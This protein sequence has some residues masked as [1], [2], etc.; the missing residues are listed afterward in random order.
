MA[1][2][3]F[4]YQGDRLHYIRKLYSNSNTKQTEVIWR[5]GLKHCGL[6]WDNTNLSTH[7]AALLV[8]MERR[9]F[10][11]FKGSPVRQ[12]K[13]FMRAESIWLLKSSLSCSSGNDQVAFA[14]LTD[15]CQ[16]CSSKKNHLVK[17]FYNCLR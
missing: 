14:I 7:C 4:R 9:S 16:T 6:S 1:G 5:R 15:L 12:V 8:H 10:G 17:R 2:N 13:V 3:I 11:Y